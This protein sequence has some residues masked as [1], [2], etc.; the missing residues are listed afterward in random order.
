MS[1]ARMKRLV[2]KI[3]GKDKEIETLK[4][5]IA[6]IMEL[7]SLKNLRKLSDQIDLLKEEIEMVKRG[8]L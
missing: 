6:T 4:N 7:S 2:D 3:E 5:L 8:K 1:E